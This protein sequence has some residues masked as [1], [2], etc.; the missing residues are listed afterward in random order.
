VQV[1]PLDEE[2]RP[3]G[4]PKSYPLILHTVSK[5]G[6]NQLQLVPVSHDGDLKG[7][8]L[9]AENEATRDRYMRVLE[10][11]RSVAE[12][13]KGAAGGEAGIDR[14]AMAVDG[15]CTSLIPETLT[16]MLLWSP[17]KKQ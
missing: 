8:R 3:K 9:T 11:A 15:V 14:K 7:I 12:A 1:V 17:G 4:I 16:H 6:K 10:L 13:S 2:G 5:V